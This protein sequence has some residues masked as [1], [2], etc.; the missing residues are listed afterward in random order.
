MFKNKTKCGIKIKVFNNVALLS[1]YKN[2]KI[3]KL[4]D[5]IIKGLHN[6][7]DHAW[8]INIILYQ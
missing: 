8:L 5:C 2:S 7:S 1:K 4:I 6:G 3:Q